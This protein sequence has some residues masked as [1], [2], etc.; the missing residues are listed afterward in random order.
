M[1]S[2]PE[3]NRIDC[4]GKARYRA[5]VAVALWHD[6]ELCLLRRSQLVGSDAGLWHCVT[7]Y[8]EPGASPEQQAQAE[9]FEET[10]LSSDRLDT[11]VTGGSFVL[12]GDDGTLWK[13]HIF[14]ATVRSRTLSLNWEH[15]QYRWVDPAEVPAAHQVWWLRNV[16][17][18]PWQ[19]DRNRPGTATG[20]DSASI[21]LRGVTGLLD[22]V[23]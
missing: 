4:R 18:D 3:R 13:V 2:A 1:G 23:S 22:T 10:G 20:H 12:A 7:G 17:A 15:D 9:L 8:L 19:A 5:V 14:H 11:L 21:A 16:L 6:S